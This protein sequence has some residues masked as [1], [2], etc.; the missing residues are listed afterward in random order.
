MPNVGTREGEAAGVEEDVSSWAKRLPPELHI[1]K[2]CL[3]FARTRQSWRRRG[4]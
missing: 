4:K 3:S 2:I 1:P